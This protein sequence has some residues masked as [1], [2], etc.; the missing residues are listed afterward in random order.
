MGH[1]LTGADFEEKVIKSKN[2]VM[3][4]F[5]APWCGPCKMMGPIIDEL[6]KEYSSKIDIYKMNVDEAG[7]LANQYQVMSIPTII[8]FKR[9][10]PINQLIG[11]QSKAK[12][13]KVLED[14]K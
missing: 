3:V 8:F 12:I 1:E 5:F 14:L 13:I 2:P 11:A 9:G 4:D 7:D 6:A 10:K